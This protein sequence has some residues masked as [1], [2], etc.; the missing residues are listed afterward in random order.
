MP[1]PGVEDEEEAQ[2]Q[3]RK[4]EEAAAID[5]ATAG[6]DA[7]F[8]PPPSVLNAPSASALLTRVDGPS[9][10]DY[11]SSESV[12]VGRSVPVAAGG[13]LSI[14][15]GVSAPGSVVECAVELRSHD[16]RFE[17]RAEREEGVTVVKV[18]LF[19]VLFA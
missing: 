8:R 17:I 13:L 6:A 5:R 3:R 16:V 2:R 1:P 12:Y 18:R 7:S 9:L 11:K 10:R 14:P 4:E 19:C 15:I